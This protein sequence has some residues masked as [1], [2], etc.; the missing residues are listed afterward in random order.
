[1]RIQ[2]VSPLVVRRLAVYL[3]ILQRMN[4]EPDRFISSHELGA[5]AGVTAAQVR[6]DLAFFGQFGKQGVG[7]HVWDLR[8]EL[9][10]ILKADREIPVGIVGIGELGAALA[11]YNLRQE[12]VQ[13]G[14]PFRVVALFD[15]DTRKIGTAVEGLIV[16]STS[17]LSGVVDELGIKIF[18]ITVPVGSAQEVTDLCVKAGIKAIVNFAPA[19][20]V[21][22]EDVYIHSSDVT[23]DLQWLAYYLHD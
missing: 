23:L 20:V 4:P 13:K 2:R 1:V 3:R 18:M 5:R 21:A 7:Y 15:N 19:K 8:K 22:P 9:C 11:R 14:Y 16:R 12:K 17:D 6:K 10:R